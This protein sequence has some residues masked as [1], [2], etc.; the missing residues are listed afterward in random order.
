MKCS[1]T[2]LDTG[3]GGWIRTSDLHAWQGVALYLLSYLSLRLIPFQATS[4]ASK[5]RSDCVSFHA[6]ESEN[7]LT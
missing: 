3:L 6:A 7:S 1:L 4:A 5:R 2:G